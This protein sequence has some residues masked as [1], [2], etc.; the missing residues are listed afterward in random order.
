MTKMDGRSN[1]REGQSLA[2]GG[3]HLSGK[4]EARTNPTLISLC[5]CCTVSAML[6]DSRA[7]VEMEGGCLR[8]DSKATEDCKEQRLEQVSGVIGR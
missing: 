7:A 1:G 5:A 3:Q 4:Q 8:N 6:T 2:S